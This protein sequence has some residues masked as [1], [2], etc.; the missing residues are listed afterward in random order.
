LALDRDEILV[1]PACGLS[2]EKDVHL[3]EPDTGKYEPAPEEMRIYASSKMA[4][5][6]SLMD[7]LSRFMPA[8][9][10]LLDVGCATGE[11]MKAA[12]AAGWDC[13]GVEISA[14][15]ASAARS[16]GFP[17]EEIPFESYGKKELFD[18]VVFHEVLSQSSDPAAQLQRAFSALKPR[19]G[20]F[21]RDYNAAFQSAASRAS[22]FPLSRVLGLRPGI[23][24]NW[25][26]T[27]ASMRAL[28]TRA[29]FEK[30]EL[31]NARPSSGDPYGTGGRLGSLSVSAFKT[32]YYVL[33]SLVSA[34]SGGKALLSSVFDARA[35]KPPEAA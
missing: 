14:R 10:R 22:R 30:I 29:G 32:V 8:G 34:S 5:I 12:R 9:G 18:A 15:L 28:L 27:P 35:R 33:A 16:A 26:F 4:V 2:R 7:E 21:I 25:N 19:G 1:C 20:V 3:P 24:H 17:V 23:M 6:G 13:A 31:R 11:L